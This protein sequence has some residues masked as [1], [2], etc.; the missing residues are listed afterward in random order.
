MRANDAFLF[1]A[2]NRPPKRHPERWFSAFSVV[3]QAK[4]SAPPRH[5]YKIDSVRAAI[6]VTGAL[7]LIVL[8]ATEL[9]ELSCGCGVLLV[10]LLAITAI[11]LQELYGSLKYL[12]YLPPSCLRQTSPPC[13]RSI[14][15]TLRW[16]LRGIKELI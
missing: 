2:D 13:Q 8:V 15:V 9:I 5:R 4:N 12:R 1:E 10:V 6:V 3:S 11:T 14:A 16:L 7:A